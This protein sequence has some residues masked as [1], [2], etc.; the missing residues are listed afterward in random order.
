M[1][2]KE[3]N[4]TF[5]DFVA[6]RNHQKC[7]IKISLICLLYQNTFAFVLQATLLPGT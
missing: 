3:E 5:D 6:R 4:D 7:Y 2:M 1:K